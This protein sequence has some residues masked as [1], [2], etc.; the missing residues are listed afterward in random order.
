MAV[1][2]LKTE[3][4]VTHGY[5]NTIV[6]LSKNDDSTDENLLTQQYEG[7][8]SLLPIYHQLLSFVTSLGDDVKIAPKKSSVSIIRKRQFILIK[9]ATKTRIDLGFKLKDH[10]ITER[11]ENS[12][13]HG[14]MST[15]RVRLTNP[16]QVDHEV[17]DCIKQ[18]YLHSMTAAADLNLRE[19]E[20][21]KFYRQV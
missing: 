7:K 15:H 20:S 14:T 3:Y 19:W 8:E 2:F 10:P 1:K 21:I 9:P 6:S 17:K 4:R 11:L 18:A 16:S 12:G 5:A 13:P